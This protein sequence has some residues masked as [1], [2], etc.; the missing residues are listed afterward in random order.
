MKLK[1]VLTPLSALAFGALA[2]SPFNPRPERS[3]E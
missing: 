1:R 2:L 3:D